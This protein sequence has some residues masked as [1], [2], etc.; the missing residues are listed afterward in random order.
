MQWR[1]PVLETAPMPGICSLDRERG[2][3]LTDA[4]A[5]AIIKLLV[6]IYAFGDA[7]DTL[8]ERIDRLGC[9][10]LIDLIET[11]LQSVDHDENDDGPC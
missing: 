9:R 6:D 11:E 10:S 5:I 8:G 2:F 3:N 4:E 1:D 7:V